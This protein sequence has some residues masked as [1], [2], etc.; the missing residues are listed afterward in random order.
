MKKVDFLNIDALLGKTRNRV[1]KMGIEFEGGW[2]KTPTGVRIERDGS[3]FKALDLG[4][5]TRDGYPGIKFGEIP[6]G[7]FLP[8]QVRRTV[9]KY[10]PHVIDVT[11]AMHVHMSFDKL[12][13]YDVLAE[14]PAYQETVVEY[15]TRWAAEE[16]LPVGHPL[17]ARLANKNVYCQKKFWPEPQMQQNRKDHDHER[18]GHRYTMIHYCWER[19]QT[20]ECRLLLMMK[21]PEVGIRGVNR[22]LDITNAYLVAAEKKRFRQGGVVNMDDNGAKI[23]LE[24]RKGQIYEE[25]FED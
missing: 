19:Y 1:A 8:I 24:L 2:N 21:D 14:S 9:L 15:L 3:V 20:V 17:W 10:S 22:L 13:H 11:C 4:A 6:V 18:F 23:T 5:L 7:P 12:F 25:Y 16:K